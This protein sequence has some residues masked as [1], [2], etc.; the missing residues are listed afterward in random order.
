MN[1]IA[2]RAFYSEDREFENGPDLL[3]SFGDLPYDGLLSVALYYD[4]SRPDGHPYRDIVSC[5]VEHAKSPYSHDYCFAV[6]SEA[7]PM[8]MFDAGPPAEIRRRYPG[9]IVK[10]GK[11]VDPETFKR[12]QQKVMASVECPT[13][14]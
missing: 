4:E 5:L 14:N 10:R 7:G 3:A 8:F 12:V 9:A 6:Q 1:I 11:G 2:W 13:C